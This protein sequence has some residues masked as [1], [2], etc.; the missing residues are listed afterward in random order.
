MVP[1]CRLPL[2]YEAKLAFVIALWHPRTHAAVTLYDSYM[3]PLLRKHEAG[4]DRFFEEC[5][6]RVADTVSSN[7]HA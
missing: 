1:T 5:R 6:G 3:L 7:V 2:Y 4:I